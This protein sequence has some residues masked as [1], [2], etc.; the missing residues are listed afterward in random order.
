MTESYEV[1]KQRKIMR[2]DLRSG[3]AT[4]TAH[5]LPDESGV[6]L[7]VSFGAPFPGRLEEIYH[8]PEPGVMH[9]TSTVFLRDQSVATTQVRRLLRSRLLCLPRL[10]RDTVAPQPTQSHSWACLWRRLKGRCKL[11][12]Y[13]LLLRTASASRMRCGTPTLCLC[14]PRSCTALA[15]HQVYRLCSDVSKQEFLAQSEKRNGKANDILRKFG[16]PL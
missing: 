7:D 3:K 5:L 8:S 6:R 14:S 13:L 9:V 11:C 16:A 12:E 10:Q 4:A 15:A 2:R 1:G